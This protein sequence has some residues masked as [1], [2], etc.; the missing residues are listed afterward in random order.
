M[1]T[2]YFAAARGR[3]AALSMLLLVA[4][5]AAVA[6]T[7][8]HA[9]DQGMSVRGRVVGPDG[10]PVAGQRVVLHRVDAAGGTTVAETET[11]EEGRFTLAAPA[12]MDTTGVFFVAARYENEL[13]IG[14]PF[15]AGEQAAEPTLHV[16][17][18]GMSATAM[19]REAEAQ[20]PFPAGRPATT[21][22][23]LLFLVPALG[24]S[25]VALYLLVPRRRIAA[26]RTLYIR[27]AEL[28]ERMDTAPEGQRDSLREERTR[29][30]E[31]LRAS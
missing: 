6:V 17:I 13:Y 15:R 5:M 18:P 21:P 16:G 2:S 22:S 4:W 7:A 8:A 28:D 1:T 23:W 29:L 25:G 14:D 26:E 31:R 11:D 19:L 12:T 9:Q 30:I 10:A 24:V 20:M 27:I 3:L